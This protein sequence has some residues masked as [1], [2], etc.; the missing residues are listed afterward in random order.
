MGRI[1]IEVIQASY[2]LLDL[3][4]HAMIRGRC[5]SFVLKTDAHFPTDINFCMTPYDA[6][7]C[8]CVLNGMRSMLCQ[9][10]GIMVFGR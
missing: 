2:R 9:A 10:D 6:P 4:I 7:L 8:I 5:D 1:N 3:D